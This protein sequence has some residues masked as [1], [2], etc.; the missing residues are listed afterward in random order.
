VE[1][2]PSDQNLVR[3]SSD[4]AG[5]PE[6]YY[7]EMSPYTLAAM[8]AVPQWVERLLDGLPVEDYAIIHH[9][10][11]GSSAHIQGTT[12]MGTDPVTSV[13]DR[14]LVHHR[15]RNLIMLGSGVFPTCPAANPTLILSALSVLAARE[16]MTS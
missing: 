13:V 3:V 5:K 10:D 14:S 16:L 2:L 4:D 6:I 12:R 9:D 7:P 15:V 1:D 11:F 8:K